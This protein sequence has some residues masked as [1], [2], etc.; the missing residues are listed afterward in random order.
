MNSNEAKTLPPLGFMGGT[1]AMTLTPVAGTPKRAQP[2]R[3]RAG[4]PDR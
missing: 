3:A 2:V 1:K 4:E